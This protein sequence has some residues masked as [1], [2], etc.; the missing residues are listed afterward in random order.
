MIHLYTSLE[1]FPSM[2]DD[3]GSAAW[4]S[5]PVNTPT[6][7]VLVDVSPVVF[8]EAIGRALSADGFTVQVGATPGASGAFDAAIVGEGSAP[9]DVPITLV[10]G[11]DS[12]VVVR[13]GG[14]TGVVSA[15]GPRDLARIVW[16]LVM[17]RGAETA[18][19]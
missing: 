11:T 6:P 18:P 16:R 1:Y 10:V 3:G 13:S 4:F 19:A 7:R 17:D 9:I 15:S 8:A 5:N 12:R 14:E 2:E